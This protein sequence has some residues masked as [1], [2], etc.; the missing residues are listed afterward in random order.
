MQKWL[1]YLVAAVLGIGVAVVAFGPG[2]GSAPKERPAKAEKADKGEKKVRTVV[3]MGADGMDLVR[4]EG[5]TKTPAEVVAEGRANPI[6][7]SGTLRPMNEGEIAHAARL[8]R[9][10]NQHFAYVSAFWNRAAQLTG[11][12][13]SDL[14][15]E[16]SQMTRLLRDQGNLDDADMDVAGTI[17]KEKALVARIRSGVPSTPELEG[18]L[19]YI[20]ES[21]QA[22]LDGK[23]P[24]TVL[25]PKQKAAAAGQ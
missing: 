7:P 12:A 8:A 6:P 4:T 1:P 9:P 15:R 19:T 24:T 2:M 16:C 13:G 23:D 5:E 20:E 17:A 3:D 14:S 18:V 10:F 22:V 21:G 11:A 25:K